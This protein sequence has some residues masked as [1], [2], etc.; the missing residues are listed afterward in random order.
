MKPPWSA[1][2]GRQGRPPAPGRTASG[3]RSSRTR[4]SCHRAR[5]GAGRAPG[6]RSSRRPGSVVT[7]SSAIASDAAPAASAAA[8]SSPATR[9]RSRRR[10]EVGAAA[11]DLDQLGEDRER[12]LLGR[13]RTEVH[14][15]RRPQRG[16]PLLGQSRLLAQPRPDGGGAGRRGDESDVAGVA[17]Q[18][19]RERLLVPLALGRDDDVRARLAVDRDEVRLGPD[20]GGGR[21]RGRRP[22]SGRRA[23]PSN[24]AAVPSSTS[25]PAI[26]VMPATHRSGLGRFGST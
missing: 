12:D 21:E 20:R 5:R 22:R 8:S 26:G 3:S 18:R 11:A 14:A 6:R 4:R 15:G 24:P 25:A 19:P 1:C 9:R 16:E 7:M 13:L 23:S 10:D 2:P 17:A